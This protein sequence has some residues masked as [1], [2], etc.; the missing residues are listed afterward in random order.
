MSTKLVVRPE[1]EAEIDEAAGWYEARLPG[2]GTEFL[3]AVDAG[4]SALQRNPAQFPLVHR[5][6]RRVVLRRFPYLILFTSSDDRV[7]IH[8]VFHFRRDPEEW[9]ERLTSPS[10]R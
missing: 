3:R 10:R 4:V 8:A 1:A 9:A 5:D 7:V 6:A 2:L